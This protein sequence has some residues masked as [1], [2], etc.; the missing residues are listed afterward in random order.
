ME[1]WPIGKEEEEA[2]IQPWLLASP[3]EAGVGRHLSDGDT[4]ALDQLT[5]DVEHKVGPVVRGANQR[6][7]LWQKSVLQPKHPKNLTFQPA[8]LQSYLPTC[9]PFQQEY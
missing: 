5:D 7:L 1:G 8:I 2:F 6:D 4:G 3:G 9:H